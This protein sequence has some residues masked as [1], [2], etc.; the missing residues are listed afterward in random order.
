[1]A[2]LAVYIS[3]L[4]VHRPFRFRIVYR[5]CGAVSSASIATMFDRPVWKAD[6]RVG[7]VTTNGQSFS[8]GGTARWPYS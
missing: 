4:E 6:V 3:S 1:M 7:I 8:L 2:P 5:L